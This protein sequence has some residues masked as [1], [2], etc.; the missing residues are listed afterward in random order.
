AK[1]LLQHTEQ[2]LKIKQ[3]FIKALNA[4]IEAYN[5][6]SGNIKTDN[7]ALANHINEKYSY[8][9]SLLNQAD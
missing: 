2:D 9:L 3:N 8:V 4:T 6:N 5:K 1:E 7:A